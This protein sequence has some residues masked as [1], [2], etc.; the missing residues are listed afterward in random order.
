MT[1]LIQNLFAISR[2]KKLV[3]VIRKALKQ[4]YIQKLS[5]GTDLNYVSYIYHE[6]N[7]MTSK[8]IYLILH[9]KKIL[10]N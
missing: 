2:I 7:S 8:N 5:I 9:S 4:P 3:Q 6:L 1:T 10:I